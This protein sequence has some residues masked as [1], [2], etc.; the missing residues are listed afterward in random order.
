MQSFLFSELGSCL[1]QTNTVS[2]NSASTIVPIMKLTR[3]RQMVPVLYVRFCQV[4]QYL[5]LMQMPC[6]CMDTKGGRVNTLQLHGQH[7]P[8]SFHCPYRKV[9]RVAFHDVTAKSNSD[10]LL[11]AWECWERKTQQC[12][13]GFRAF[14]WLFPQIP[15]M[16]QH[17]MKCPP[18]HTANLSVVITV[19]GNST[20]IKVFQLSKTPS[21]QKSSYQWKHLLLSKIKV[22]SLVFYLNKNINLD[23]NYQQGSFWEGRQ[24][25][26]HFPLCFSSVMGHIWGG[27]KGLSCW[28]RQPRS[29]SLP[30]HQKPQQNL[31]VFAWS[32]GYSKSNSPWTG[33][34]C[35]LCFGFKVLNIFL[36]EKVGGNT[37]TTQDTSLME[38]EESVIQPKTRIEVILLF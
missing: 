26:L 31:L 24:S 33:F 10:R 22:L 21:L 7:G 27:R 35:R 30:S 36:W 4:Y 6:T 9:T 20:C 2:T 17:P 29:S 16:Q 38:L 3:L 8:I 18:P 12:S 11:E 23:T 34:N 19:L 28:D 13:A 1:S 15:L 14:L 37:N 25:V 5:F 32:P